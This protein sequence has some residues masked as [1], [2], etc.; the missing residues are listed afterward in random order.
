MKT[1]A[2]KRYWMPV[3][4]MLGGFA[5]PVAQADA[6]MNY[7]REFSG[8]QSPSGP[9][10]WATATFKTISTGTVDLSIAL[11][12]LTDEEF[13]SEAYFNFAPGTAAAL[14]IT[15]TGGTNFS[16]KI[17]VGLNDRKADGAGFF[18]ILIEFDK[19]P[20]PDRFSVGD[21]ATFRITGAG[22]TAESF[23]AFSTPSDK[24]VFLSALHVQG[25][26]AS[27]DGSGWVGAVPIPAAVWLFGSALV[28]LAG[29]GYRR[30]Q[31]A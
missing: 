9:T 3:L 27:A 5:M 14:N 15:E 10:P 6:V 24:G 20:P 17:S 2:F 1:N 25:I 19:A 28:G 31:A 26:G 30:K 16:E 18:D 4:I 11:S 22:I 8:A 29:L 21:I 23:F 13:V 12:G 7:D